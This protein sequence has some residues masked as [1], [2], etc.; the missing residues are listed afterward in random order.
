MLTIA[1]RR[2]T[3]DVSMN[4]NGLFNPASSLEEQAMNV[5]AIYAP[6]KTLDGY[7]QPGAFVKWR[8]ATVSIQLPQR[9]LSRTG[10]RSASVVFSG[11]N[12]KLW[13]HYRGSDPESDFTATGGGDAPAEFQTFAA[14]TLF[15]FR[16][17]IGY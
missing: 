16:L 10:A 6:E 11:R 5:A 4:C 12:L 8:E 14:P 13:T 17:N 15:Q 3:A 9:L 2:V 1:G 7:F